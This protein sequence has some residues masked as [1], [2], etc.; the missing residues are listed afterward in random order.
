MRSKILTM[1][2][3]A[4]TTA[5]AVSGLAQQP[6]RPAAPGAGRSAAP[7]PPIATVGPLSISRSD[8]ESRYSTAMD[9]YRMRTG[10]AVPAEFEPIV[11]RQVLEGF[12]RRDLLVLE[13]PRQGITITD[14]EAEAELKRDPFF[15]SGGS[16]NET[17]FLAVKN[18][19]PQAFAS[20][21][22]L[23]RQQ[24]A[25]RRLNE[26]LERDLSEPEPVLRARAERALTRASVEYLGL[27]RGEFLTDAPE[28]RESAVLGY[29]RSHADEFRRPDRATLSVAFVNLPALAD[30]L[31][32]DAGAA[33]AWNDRM[34]QRADSALARVRAGA[35]LE[36]AAEPFGAPRQ[37]VVV[38]RDNFPGFWQGD[39][40]LGASIFLKAP[41]TVLAE[42]VAGK[43]G[44]LLVRVDEVR[45]AHVAP[46]A[47]VA[48]EIRGRL[49]ADARRRSDDL[50]LRALYDG[51]RDSLRITTYRVRYAVAD[52]AGM[53][54]GV[55][56]PADLDRYYRA[57]LAD[58][59][60]YDPATASVRVRS[61]AAVEDDVRLRWRH[62]RRVEL[63]RLAIARIEDLWRHG[64]RDRG[65]EGAV[66]LFR[67]VGPVALGAP[68]DTGVAGGALGDSLTA[69][70]GAPGV[71]VGPTPRGPMVFDVYQVLHD[72]LPEFEQA[73]PTLTARRTEAR[74]RRDAV[75][76]RA[77]YDRDPRQFLGADVVHFTRV[78][79]PTVN[80]VD[81]PLTRDEVERYHREHIDK[82]SAPELMRARHILISPAD[83]GPSADSAARAKAADI[84]RRV[85]AGED[86]GTLASR[87][88][89]DP[90][91]KDKGGDLGTFGRG[92]ML[93]E[94]ERVAFTLRPDEVS[95]LVKT[96]VGYHIIKC[97]NRESAVAQPLVWIYANVG[98]DAAVEKSKLLAKQRADSL[99]VAAKTPARIFAVARSMG[100]EVANLEFSVGDHRAIAELLPV[101]ERLEK[102][103]PGQAY[104]GSYEVPGLGYAL[105]WVDSITPPP[106]PTWVQA[107][108]RAIDAWRGGAD[109]R[110]LDAKCAEIDSLLR[111][112]WSLD[113]AAALWGG[114]Q[115]E[116]ALT[117]GNGL[118]GLG[119]SGIIDSLVFGADSP[120]VLRRGDV[121]AWL[122]VPMGAARLRLRERVSPDA[123]RL[124][125][126]VENDR[127][128]RLERKLFA[129]FEGLKSRS[130][131]RILDPVLRNVVL[132]EPPPE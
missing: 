131:V 21:L 70:A 33:R 66:T 63:A 109:Q 72:Q 58:Y 8:V 16:L 74:D 128:E 68:P 113:S 34:K 69:R 79:V 18:G 123:T 120:P 116:Q 88:S 47:E 93:E 27:R 41:G 44:W 86:F 5:I 107:R 1:T 97:M 46:L 94:F 59:S 76:A 73:R 51:L 126:R 64:R 125:S 91:T 110:A 6:T 30:S 14:A 42:P 87:Y 48:R 119:A 80:L 7:G 117:P 31:V 82:Y 3:I 118:H 103:R 106:T 100:D 84:L 12:I 40:R 96:E 36:E 132:P 98:A 122:A 124:A 29:Y 15:Q 89:D 127:R 61:L 111:G 78:L 50:E 23:I 35:S 25:A 71:G 101:L 114:L 90:A 112:G 39:E 62:D 43:P 11:H 28:P 129:Y 9:Q 52:T 99:Y 65:A 95:D 104:P 20:A 19:Q 55:P 45:P 81:V 130:P 37:N 53:N 26:R 2:L 121:S 75:S 83:P 77:L 102:L 32:G 17:R 115:T 4:A 49:R 13:A 60:S 38:T 24:L 92:V 56:R 85:R 22:A 57:H 67:E 54:P 108:Q 10:S 105:S